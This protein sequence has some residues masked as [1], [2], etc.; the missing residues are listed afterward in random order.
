MEVAQTSRMTTFIRRVFGATAL[1][2]A[3]YEEI[4]ADRTSLGQ[5]L[6]VVLLSALAAGVGARGFGGRADF[7]PTMTVVALVAWVAWAVLTYQIGVRLL[8]DA[9]TRSDIPEMMRTMGFAAAPGI[10]RVVG[11][12]PV[13]TTPV[14]ALTA[15]WMLLAMVVAVRQALDY[16]STARALAVC[17]I[18]WLVTLAV[19][20]GLGMLSP[21]ALTAGR[22]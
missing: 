2:A 21:P 10:L 15:V 9:N 17:A 22:T 3:V 11:V 16:R 20:V 6:A 1:S 14:F 12:I 19:V 5:A 7:I 18:G 4:E 8:P 13:L